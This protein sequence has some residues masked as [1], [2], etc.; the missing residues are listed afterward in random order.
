MGKLTQLGV[1]AGMAPLDVLVAP[2]IEWLDYALQQQDS[3]SPI[4]DMAYR[5]P[6]VAAFLMR[7]G[8]EHV[9]AVATVAQRRLNTLYDFC[10]QGRYD[11]YAGPEGYPTIP[12]SYRAFRI[13]NPAL[14]Q[15]GNV[16][17]PD[18]YDMTMLAALPDAMPRRSHRTQ[19]GCNRRLHSG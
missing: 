13:V 2:F 3:D 8:Y 11:I 5:I 16:A 18:L 6:I 1:H 4:E 12:K 9:P 14:T 7:A 17:L 15:S 19:A 10:R